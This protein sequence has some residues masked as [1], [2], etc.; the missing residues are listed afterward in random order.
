MTFRTGLYSSHFGEVRP[1]VD[2]DLAEAEGR[3]PVKRLADWLIAQGSATTASLD[4]L[5]RDESDQLE[6]TFDE[7]MLEIRKG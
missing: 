3:D 5:A 7:V 4:A 6:K 2:A 1:G